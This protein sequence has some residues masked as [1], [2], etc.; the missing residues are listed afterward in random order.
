MRERKI[1]AA[2]PLSP[3]AGSLGTLGGSGTSGTSGDAQVATDSSLSPRQ[4]GEGRGEGRTLD[5]L[6]LAERRL[7]G[8]SFCRV[9][10]QSRPSP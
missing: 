1:V 7:S 5:T 2:V 6:W 10:R 4:R 8:V 3:R 9:C